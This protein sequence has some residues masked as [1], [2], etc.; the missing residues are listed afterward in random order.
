[1]S[2]VWFF[3]SLFSHPSFFRSCPHTDVDFCNIHYEKRNQNLPENRKLDKI[4]QKIN[5]SEIIFLQ[6]MYSVLD[7]YLCIHFFLF[8][9]LK[10]LF[11]SSFT[12]Y[13]L[14]IYTS[15]YIAWHL[16]FTVTWLLGFILKWPILVLYSTSILILCPSISKYSTSTGRLNHTRNDSMTF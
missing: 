4:N 10:V 5:I 8:I 14:I 2:Q 15:V 7:T 3:P 9:W 13:I 11:V 1:M 16:S 12:P 6:S